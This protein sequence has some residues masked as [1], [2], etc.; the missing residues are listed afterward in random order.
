M[1]KAAVY[2]TMKQNVL[3]PQGKAS[4]EALKA[5]GYEEVSSVRIGKYIELKLDTNNRAEAEERVKAMC[6]Q[7]LVNTVVEDYR[8][9]LTEE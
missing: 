6:E 9:E 8:F 2:V 5:L 1:L 7:L 3:D 4:Q